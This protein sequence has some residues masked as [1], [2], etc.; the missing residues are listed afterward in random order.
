MC[1]TGFN[2][3]INYPPFIL[4]GCTPYN[5]LFIFLKL[6]TCDLIWLWWY[7]PP[8]PLVLCLQAGYSTLVLICHTRSSTIKSLSVQ[9][10]HARIPLE[11]PISIVPTN[12]YTIHAYTTHVHHMCD[13]KP[14]KE[15]IVWVKIEIINSLLVRQK[16]PFVF[17]YWQRQPSN[18]N[19]TEP[20]HKFKKLIFCC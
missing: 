11:L 7:F 10:S 3:G 4:L 9:Y 20:T 6:S 17:Y 19:L 18:S 1:V 5:S 2:R 15:V 12:H 14:F 16:T 13:H 8:L